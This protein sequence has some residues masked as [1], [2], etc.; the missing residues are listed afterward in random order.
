MKWVLWLLVIIM[1]LI[2]S[3]YIGQDFQYLWGFFIG[4]TVLLFHNFD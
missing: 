1:G 2:I 4:G 3:Q